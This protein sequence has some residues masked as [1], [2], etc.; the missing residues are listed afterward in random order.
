MSDH[1]LSNPQPAEDL[2]HHLDD[3]K[4][5]LLLACS[6]SVAT[7]KL[8]LIIAAL[9]K[10]KNLSIR[11]V[12][13]NAS[14]HFLAGQE[15]EQPSLQQVRHMNNVDAI[16]FDQDE[17]VVPWSRGKAIL[18]IELR[19]WADLMLIAPL[20][21]NTL[22]KLANG[23]SDNL[24]TSIVRAWD[25]SKR[26]L[27]APAGNTAMWNHPMTSKQLAIIN[28]WEWIEVHRPQAGVLACGDAGDGKMK[29]WSQLVET[30]EKHLN[31]S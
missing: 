24:L 6:G 14:R 19:R 13:T 7:I 23:L 10:H 22:A 29:D 20:S 27:V 15:D 26:L 30:V 12:M 16:Y 31:L 5:H 1:S 17:W 8:P 2:A 9:G 4:V 18:H 11:I 28:E 3:G 21:L 25:P